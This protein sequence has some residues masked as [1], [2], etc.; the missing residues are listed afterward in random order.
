M[1]DR[2]YTLEDLYSHLSPDGLGDALKNETRKQLK[3]TDAKSFIEELMLLCLDPTGVFYSS[4][5]IK[6][7]VEEYFKKNEAGE[8]DA[9]KYLFH[10]IGSGEIGAVN[11]GDQSYWGKAKRIEDIVPTLAFL[12]K[13][14]SS[15]RKVSTFVTRSP[16]LSPA[17]RGTNSIDFFLNYIP[18]V[19]ASQMVP[20]LDVE[21]ELSRGTGTR[22]DSDISSP[23]LMR[24]LLGSKKISDLSEADKMIELSGLQTVESKKPD[25]ESTIY[26]FSGMEM[27]LAPQSLTNMDSLYP[28]G[29]SRLARAKPFLPFASIEGFDVQVQNA[30]AGKFAHKT[31]TL[32]MKIHDKARISEFAEFI[33]GSSGYNRAIV[34]TTYGWVAPRIEDKSSPNDYAK[35]IND[36]MM[37]RE[38]WQVVNP[39]FTFDA[40]GQVSLTIALVSKSIRKIQETD[41]SSGFS[42][43]SDAKAKLDKFN[44]VLDELRRYKEKLDQLSGEGK[45][46]ID[47]KAEQVLNAASTTGDI[48]NIEKIGDIV[49]NFLKS[50]S[51]NLTKDDLNRLQTD[52]DLLKT[53]GASNIYTDLKASIAKGVNARFN[54]LGE[55][56][57]DP[58]LPNDENSKIYGGE[59]LLASIKT[60]NNR[61]D[62]MNTQLKSDVKSQNPLRKETLKTSVVSFGKLFLE[63]VAPAIMSNA[64]NCDE[65]QIFFYSMNDQCGPASAH[66][67]AEFPINM[68]KFEY[69]YAEAIK[70]AGTDCLSL[71][72]FMTLIIQTQFDDESSI[73]YG[74][75][76]FYEPFNPD[77]PAA[78]K[79]KEGDAISTKMAEWTGKYGA[80]KKPIIEMFMES[81]EQSHANENIVQS[82][83]RGAYRLKLESDNPKVGDK[84]IIKRI[85]IFDKQSNPNKLFQQIIDTGNG[86]FTLGAIN[87][88]RIQGKLE[89]F[90]NNL[91][92]AKKTELKKLVK[93]GASQSYEAA[94]K[95]M[96]LSLNELDFIE[97][98][99]NLDVKIGKDPKS[100]KQQMMRFVPCIVVGTN[101]SMVITAN[102]SSKTDG[103]MGAINIQNARE[104]KG[105]SSST[106]SGGLIENGG[107]PLRT[108]PAQLTMTT[109][110]VPNAQYGQQYYVDFDTG[111]TLD[112]LYTATHIQHSISNGKFT[113]NWTFTYTDGYGK[114]S[115]PPT[116]NQAMIDSIKQTVEDIAKKIK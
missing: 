72:Q 79:Q 51:S 80:L 83:K 99:L 81:G 74:K 110:G 9:A 37:I 17:A 29:K 66:S 85:H 20:Y 28:D 89:A 3:Q 82:L 12:N 76:S 92:N 21:F 67:I 115:S 86:T 53:K 16:Y 97:K 103:L 48:G 14:S 69:A 68:L 36:K 54:E 55:K 23:S 63:F 41:V 113:T 43:S 96:G 59:D 56:G 24:F 8:S 26:A 44:Q 84:Y 49:A 15:K 88:N 27:F 112:N 13:D 111:T 70:N 30:G 5:V 39:Q 71:E 98:P 46:A 101:S 91:D 42:S 57:L 18:P 107:L 1:A 34:W 10:M 2:V 7:K 77:D 64:Q 32:R 58:F 33:R 106:N 6:S 105:A 22:E 75:N 73:A 100:L 104:K 102:M 52:L 60:F 87:K 31:A 50:L 93:S 61:S 65:L 11:L 19:I 90:I 38:C 25:T 45:F 35:F 47:V 95:N 108:V 114:Y 78:A 116:A 40:A 62:K 109:M 4:E 94:L